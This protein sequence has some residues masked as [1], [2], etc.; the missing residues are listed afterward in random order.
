M[1]IES[2]RTAVGHAD[3]AVF[4]FINTGLA[5]RPLDP[6]MLVATAIGTGIVQ[7]AGSLFLVALGTIRDGVDLRRAGYA[8]FIAMAASGAIVQVVKV[9]WD[10]PRPALALYDVRI[11]GDPLFAHSFPSGHT[12][13]AFAVMVAWSIMLPKLKWTLLVLAALTGFSRIYLGVHFPLDVIYGAVI[14]A[15]IGFASVRILAD[16]DTTSRGESRPSAAM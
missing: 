14:G 12:M 1:D 9:I 10:R 2:I 7:S 13:A 3:A 5:W 16:A 15:L 6:V 4:R 8:G 11:V